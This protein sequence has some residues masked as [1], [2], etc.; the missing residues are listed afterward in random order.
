MIDQRHF[1]EIDGIPEGSTF[2][3]RKALHDSGV[4]KPLQAG[5]SGS[6][7]G[8]ADS[9]VL[10][11]GYDDSDRGEIIE[12]TGEGGKA[13]NSSKHIKDQVLSKGNLGLAI[14]KDNGFPVRVIR[15]SNLTSKHAPKIGYKYGG[16]YRV[17]DWWT[18]KVDGFKVFR[19]KLVKIEPLILSEKVPIAL[20]LTGQVSGVTARR[21]KFQTLRIIRDTKKSLEIKAFYNYSCQICSLRLEGPI[22]PYA[23]A[24]HIK[25]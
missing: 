16:L 18:D 20:K 1:G 17:E 22:G 11:G 12:Y 7:K 3:N 4:H 15:G 5:I 23:E 19:Y 8:G 13:E 2:I 24:A 21:Q 10:S 14:S 9:V 6:G 25:P